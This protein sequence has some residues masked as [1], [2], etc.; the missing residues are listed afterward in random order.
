[1]SI[2][3][4]KIIFITPQFKNGGGNRVFV[5]LANSIS[6]FSDFNLEIAYPNNSKELNHYKVE[7]KVQIKAIGKNASKLTAKLFNCFLL[8]SYITKE[9]KVNNSII[10]ISE[11]I[12]CSLLW[13][14]PSKFYKNIIRYI[15]AD[16][17]N[18]F[19]DLFVL[20]NRFF[21]FSFKTLTRLSYKLNVKYVFNSHFSYKKFI[22]VSK[23]KDVIEV[24][25]HPSVDKKIFF[26]R[27][28]TD[29][30][31]LNHKVSICLVAR[32]HPLKRT[33]D[34]IAVW[35]N[36]NFKIKSKVQEVFFISTD[37]LNKFNLDD[38]TVIRP[39]NDQEIAEIFRKC[40]I[41]VSTSLWE[42]FSLPPL[43][44]LNCGVAVITSNSGG[45]SEYAINEFNALFYEPTDRKQLE[46][47]LILLIND[48]NLRNRL[49]AN[50]K[51]KTQDM[52]WE[53]SALKLMEVL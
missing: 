22:G 51:I 39:I 14:I 52:T 12:L 20:K 8:F 21:L 28:I 48:N 4:K 50:S 31:S 26:D 7:D 5:E 2:H 44:A 10:I 30:N 23:R 53:K 29:S 19:N 16:D 18:L 34:F 35:S 27:K 25:I 42:G 33:E 40:D 46:Q 45:V 3:T 43:E 36:L 13:A 32:D 37:K 41:F 17:Y 24:I 9:I 6:R 11:P 38:F 1:M 47:K 49:V 15:Q